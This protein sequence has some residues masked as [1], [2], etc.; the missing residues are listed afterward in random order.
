MSR[1]GTAT[2]D[3][4]APSG[5]VRPSGTIRESDRYRKTVLAPGMEETGEGA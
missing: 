5:T 2:T 3:D 1:P 4:P